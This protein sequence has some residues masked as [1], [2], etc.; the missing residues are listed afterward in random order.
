MATHQLVT[1]T[2]TAIAGLS[3]NTTYTVQLIGG[4]SVWLETAAAAPAADSL[5]ASFVEAPMAVR[6]QNGS[7]EATY[8]WA[9]SLKLNSQQRIVI[10]EAIG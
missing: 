3:D 1:E 7:G 6:V 5:T 2:P 9:A 10:N 4:G 8:V